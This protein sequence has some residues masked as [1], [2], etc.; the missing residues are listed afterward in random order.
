MQSIVSCSLC[1]ASKALGDKGNKL[2]YRTVKKER[3]TVIVGPAGRVGWRAVFPNEKRELS[4]GCTEDRRAGR[5]AV[6]KGGPAG[7]GKER[8]GLHKRPPWG[9]R[10]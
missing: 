3:I 7:C 4:A 1:K 2:T 5:R 6:Q 9:L 8:G 10:P